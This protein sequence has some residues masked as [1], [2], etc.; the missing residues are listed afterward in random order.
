MSGGIVEVVEGLRCD[1]VMIRAE[2]RQSYKDFYELQPGGAIAMDLGASGWI[3][4]VQ[5]DARL[6]CQV[7][8]DMEELCTLLSGNTTEDLSLDELQ[9][10]A[11]DHLRP[12]VRRYK[13]K[14]VEGDFKKRWRLKKSL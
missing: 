5:P 7:G 14:L 2:V 8:V 13:S 1:W 12:S 4:E 9:R 6:L 10:V 11:K 3:L